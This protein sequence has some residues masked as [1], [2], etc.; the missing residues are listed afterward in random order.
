MLV[1]IRSKSSQSTGLD[2]SIVPINC[3]SSFFDT[4]RDDFDGFGMSDFTFLKILGGRTRG[5]DVDDD[6]VRP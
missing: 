2:S 6:K 5:I 1:C 4:T 3:I